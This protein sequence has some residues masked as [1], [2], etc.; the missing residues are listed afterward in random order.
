[1]P[2]MPDRSTRRVYSCITEF[3]TCTCVCERE[4]QEE[5]RRYCVVFQGLLLLHNDMSVLLFIII[6]SHNY[7]H[8]YIFTEPT[9]SHLQFS[10]YTPGAIR[11]RQHLTDTC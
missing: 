8:I 3:S 10:A 9:I 11:M 4:K 1:M 7:T 5:R 2:C 6:F